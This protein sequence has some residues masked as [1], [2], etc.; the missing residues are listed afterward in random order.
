M[1]IRLAMF[2]HRIEIENRLPHAIFI[3]TTSHEIAWHREDW[4]KWPSG[5]WRHWIVE[6]RGSC[7]PEA[8]E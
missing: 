5:K 3:S 2:G 1:S 4:F 7:R 6:K 8:G